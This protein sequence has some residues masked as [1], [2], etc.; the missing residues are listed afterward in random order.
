MGTVDR[1]IF[2]RQHSFNMGAKNGKPELRPQ[3]IED[4]KESS[5]FTEEQI[6]EAFQAFVTDHPNGKMKPKDF[7][8]MMSKALPKKDASKMEKH[9]FRIY[10]TN[11][12]GY[13]DFVEFM[14][15]YHIMGK[16]S[17]EE[18]LLKI[19][20][21]FDYNS[22]GNITNKEMKRLIG[23]MYGL[24]KAEDPKAASEAMIA[25][26]AFAEMDENQDGKVS[27]DEFVSACMQQD[28]FSKM[29][30]IHVI[31]IFVEDPDDQ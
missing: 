21:L 28:E 16:G 6:K 17:P 9:V 22:D 3:D 2:C 13:I 14:M 29:L 8:D 23:A 31:D 18:V 15:I 10:D 30:A 11:N 1:L 26:T 24:I 5:G 4:L 12:D 25:K 7:R 20:R 27:K 19:F